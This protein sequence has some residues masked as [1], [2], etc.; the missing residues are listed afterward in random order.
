MAALMLPVAFLAGSPGG[1]ALARQDAPGCEGLTAYREA[2][3]GVGRYLNDTS[4]AA[5]LD[6][7]NIF[8]YS[9]DDWTVYAEITLEGQ[10]RLKAITPPDFAA[11]YHHNLIATFG[12]FEQIG[13]ASARDGS[14]V[15]SDFSDQI[16][17]LNQ[18][19]L[20][21]TAI[22]TTICADFQELADTW[23]S[24]SSA[25]F[26]VADAQPEATVTEAGAKPSPTPAVQTSAASFETSG[27]GVTWTDVNLLPGAYTFRLKC[28]TSGGTAG[29]YLPAVGPETIPITESGTRI[30][31]P[32]IGDSL[33][34]GLLNV[35]CDGSWTLVA[36]P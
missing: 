26:P 25:A 31:I 12:L 33:V 20:D 24:Q 13:R 1:Q 15:L 23:G 3:Y 6:D 5:G 36:T 16:D 7:R 28:D 4:A 35:K 17:E 19:D 32:G 21:T 11:D 30:T 18:R 34:L 9:S 27:T 8:T 14:T 22:A 10:R 29:I 2:M